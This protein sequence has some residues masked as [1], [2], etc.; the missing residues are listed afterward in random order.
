M[1]CVYVRS[2]VGILV[3]MMKKLVRFCS[4]PSFVFVQ[5]SSHSAVLLLLLLLFFFSNISL[6]VCYTFSQMY[7]MVHPD[8]YV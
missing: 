4:W 3:W 2:Y 5:C 6:L 8:R 1:R 7:E